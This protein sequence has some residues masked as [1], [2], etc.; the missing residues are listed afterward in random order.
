MSMQKRIRLQAPK[1][2]VK[3]P[4]L[5]GHWTGILLNAYIAK[6]VAGT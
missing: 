1:K 3:A 6:N 2:N 5:I 4:I